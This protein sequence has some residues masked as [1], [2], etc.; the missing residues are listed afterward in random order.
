MGTWSTSIS[1][2]DTARDL[3]IEYSVAFYKYETEEA[4]KVIDRYVRSEM[5]DES[6]PEEWCNYYYSLAD[7]MW[8]KGILTDAVRSRAIE[9][10]DTG[11]GLELWEEAGQKTLEARKKKLQEFRKKLLSPLPPRKRIKPDVYLDRIFEDG[12]IVALQLHT[13][14]KPYSEDKERPLS[15]EEFQAFHG[16][17]VLMQFVNCYASWTSSIVPE[18]KDNWARFRLFDGVYDTVP[19]DIDPSS[20]KEAMIHEGQ[21]ISPFFTCES[22]LF[23]F[24]KRNYKVLCNRKDLI[25]DGYSRSNNHI[26]W[27]VDKPWKNPDSQILAAMDKPI[28]CG[29]FAGSETRMREICKFANRYGRYDARIPRE[30][31]EARFLVEKELIEK[32]INALLTGWTYDPHLS[33]EENEARFLAEEK[34]IADRINAVLSRGGQA[35]GIH[36]GKEIGLLTIENDHIDNLYIEGRYQGNGFGTRL[37]EFAFSHVGENGYI[38]VPTTNANLL[39]ICEKIG[40]KKTQTHGGY[41][42]YRAKEP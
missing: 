21:E 33:R 16:K 8:K 32:R 23:Y 29:K 18:V 40:L 35:Y 15:P 13:E 7:F 20:L 1:G 37:L 22:S 27:R 5:F 30:T 6:D 19:E 4:V 25:P 41:I 38:N 17:Y 42:V 24:K 11:F 12:D 31:G 36:F 10:I 28:F 9:M 14:G 39:H 34:Q 3:Y 26:H 2:N